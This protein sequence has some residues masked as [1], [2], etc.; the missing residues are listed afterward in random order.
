MLGPPGKEG[1]IGQPGPMGAPGSRG[2]SGELGEQV[3]QDNS[4]FYIATIG[5]LV[6]Y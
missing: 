3:M 2:S 4:F 6:F 1:N 5:I